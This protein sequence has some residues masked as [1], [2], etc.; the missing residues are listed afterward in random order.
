MVPHGK[1][2]DRC[3]VV[4]ELVYYFDIHMV[5]MNFRC[6]NSH[7]EES[8]NAFQDDNLL[9]HYPIFHYEAHREVA[10]HSIGLFVA[11]F[12]LLEHNNSRLALLCKKFG[13]DFAIHHAFHAC[14]CHYSAHVEFVRWSQS[15]VYHV[16]YFCRG[17]YVW[18][19]S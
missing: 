5:Y 11:N 12:L 13:F 8:D 16:H 10:N 14:G 19:T 15:R 2:I 7:A 17:S 3:T 4:Y 9:P 18:M 1:G 6:L